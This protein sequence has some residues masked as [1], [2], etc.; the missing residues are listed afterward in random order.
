MGS[1]RRPHTRA[2]RVVVPQLPY[3]QSHC[4]SSR[5][6]ISGP[7]GRMPSRRR[8]ARRSNWNSRV[9]KTIGYSTVEINSH[10]SKNTRC[11]TVQ[12]P[13]DS[14]ATS[15]RLSRSATPRC[16]KM[17][18]RCTS[19]LFG[20]G[21]VQ[22]WIHH[23]GGSR[24]RRH[25]RARHRA[26]HQ[27]APVRRHTSGPAHAGSGSGIPDRDCDSRLLRAGLEGRARRRHERTPRRIARVNRESI[28]A[29][30]LIARAKSMRGGSSTT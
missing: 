20:G 22:A 28:A 17:T 25:R 6:R 1:Y 16:S 15:A 7:A 18:L 13:R 9:E 14:S 29:P 27:D 5:L 19:M 3:G 21:P 2:C 8:A 24:A 12:F 30:A 23:A 10:S 26:R 4:S 11:K